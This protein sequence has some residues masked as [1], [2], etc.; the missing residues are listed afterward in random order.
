MKRK[1]YEGLVQPKYMEFFSDTSREDSE[2]MF[3]DGIHL[4]HYIGVAHEFV[5]KISS[6]TLT[7]DFDNLYN[8]VFGDQPKW[9]Y[10]DSLEKLSDDFIQGLTA[11]QVVTMLV[12]IRHKELFCTGFIKL[13]GKSG[14]IIRLLNQLKRQLD[15]ED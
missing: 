13:C 4:P 2:Y 8:N 6:S 15:K 11:T 10:V 7:V 14:T 5:C 1:E 3:F 9:L 12:A